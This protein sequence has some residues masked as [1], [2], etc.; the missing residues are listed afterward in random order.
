MK[1]LTLFALLLPGCT[2]TSDL[3]TVPKVNL[4]KYMGT[5]YEIA[6]LPNGF[7]RGC[8]HT[9]ANYTL[10]NDN[11]VTVINKCLYKGNTDREKGS[12]GSAYVT[13]PSTNSK[14]KVTF[15]WPFYGAYWI[16]DLADDYSYAVVASPDKDYLWIL[17]R[18]P[19]MSQEIYDKLI[20]S[21]AEKGFDVSRVKKTYHGKTL[22]GQELDF[23][24]E[25]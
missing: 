3:Q 11:T 23:I 19:Q 17:N 20:K 24:K 13:E 16:I 4:E 25:Y 7:Q 2:T 18:K 22:R 15:F 5:W 14:L 1:W 8:T 12:E 6:R 21:T 9:T 10:N